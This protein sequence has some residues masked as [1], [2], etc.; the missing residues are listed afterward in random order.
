MTKNA[1]IAAALPMLLF[2]ASA[3]ADDANIARAQALFDQARVSFE[4]ENYSDACPK[5]EESK[6]IANG[7]GV[8]LYLAACDDALGKKATALLL[9]REAEGMARAR[10]DAREQ[11]AHQAVVDLDGK[12]ARIRMHLSKASPQAIVTDNGH[13]VGVDSRGF[14]ADP[15]WHRLAVTDAGRKWQESVR[16]P[17]AGDDA[18]PP[19]LDVFVPAPDREAEPPKSDPLRS[20]AL[21]PTRSAP[22]GSTQKAIGVGLAAA[23]AVSI[24]LGT[25]FGVHAISLRNE[26]NDPGGGCDASDQCDPHG[27]SLRSSAL[28][29]A[30]IS[31]VLFAVGGAAVVGGVVLYVA[32][33]TRSDMTVAFGPTGATL[34]GSF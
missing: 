25:Y 16:V 11:I 23:G 15:G 8:T 17:E 24:G 28:E 32:A 1:M 12:T 9:Y 14:A 5:F 4:S 26:S 19:V 13:V 3:F 7:L 33:P 34:R 22:T 21:A 27:Q 6:R 31:T 18:A 30:T 10:G 20:A 29:S 2:S